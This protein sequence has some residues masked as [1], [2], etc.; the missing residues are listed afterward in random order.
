MSGTARGRWAPIV[1]ALCVGAAAAAGGLV[2][3]GDPRALWIGAAVAAISR[4]AGH[5]IAHRRPQRPFTPHELLTVARELARDT[6]ALN[7][8]VTVLLGEA[9]LL[10]QALEPQRG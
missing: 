3:S 4:G 9:E 7:N 6:H 8:K 2:A 5:Y 10:V 1:H